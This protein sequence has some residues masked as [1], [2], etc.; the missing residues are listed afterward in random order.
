MK[1][2]RRTAFAA[3][4]IASGALTAAGVAIAAN[5]GSTG[6]TS[7]GDLDITAQIP[8]LV[9]ITKLTDIDLGSWDGSTDMTGSDT[10]CVWSTTRAYTVTATGDGAGGAFTLSDGTNTLP[11]AVS[12]EDDSTNSESL[13]SGS[14]SGSMSATTN[15]ASCSGGTNATVSVT[16]TSANAA[17]VPAGTYNGTLTL[18][19]APD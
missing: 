19:V 17:G 4:M 2:F 14:P 18:E 16:V 10:V 11:Y 5:D 8:D 1:Y 12:W 9:R 7:T 13:S 15:S 3:A 6:A